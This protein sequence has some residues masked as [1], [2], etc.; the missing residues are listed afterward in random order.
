MVTIVDGIE[1]TAIDINQARKDTQIGLRKRAELSK[2]AR[3]NYKNKKTAKFWNK[4]DTE[5]RYDDEPN[6]STI[7]C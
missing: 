6:E 7:T 2:D 5:W 4:T 3:S 1:D